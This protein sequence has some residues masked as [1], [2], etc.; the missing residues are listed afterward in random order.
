MT[1][2]DQMIRMVE[3]TWNL[4][5]RYIRKGYIGVITDEMK[6]GYYANLEAD[7]FSYTSCWEADEI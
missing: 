3:E 6:I 5:V 4:M 2:F 7:R 1:G